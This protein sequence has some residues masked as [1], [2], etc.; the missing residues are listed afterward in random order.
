M[1]AARYLSTKYGKA[2]KSDMMQIVK[3]IKRV[4]DNPS[5]MVIPNLGVPED[6]IELKSQFQP[7]H[8]S[9]HFL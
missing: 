4:K 3:L 9:N 8:N 6:W 1:Y 2:T 5:N 7:D